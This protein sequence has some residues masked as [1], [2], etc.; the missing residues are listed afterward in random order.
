MGT[1][2][3]AGVSL[4]ILLAVL[5]YRISVEPIPEGASRPWPL[6]T[7]LFLARIQLDYMVS[8]QG[9]T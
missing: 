1:C 6:R 3:T 4:A 9:F 5:V 8:Y 2:K 7:M